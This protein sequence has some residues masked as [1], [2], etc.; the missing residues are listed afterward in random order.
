MPDADTIQ[1]R[2]KAT[3]YA[4]VAIPIIL[5][6]LYLLPVKVSGHVVDEQTGQPMAGVPVELGNGQLVQTDAQGQFA[7]RTIRLRPV[8]A[9]VDVEGYQPWEGRSA[10]S[11]LPLAAARLDVDVPPNRLHGQVVDTSSGQP[12]A[13]VTISASGQSTSIHFLTPSY[14]WASA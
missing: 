6:V 1:T 13:G 9:N 8:T 5:L 7:T 10:F 2:Q 11:W 4:L 3:L 12:V 14:P